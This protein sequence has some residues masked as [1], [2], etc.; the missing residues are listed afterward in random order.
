MPVLPAPAHHGNGDRIFTLVRLFPDHRAIG[1]DLRFQSR[2]AVLTV[3]SDLMDSEKFPLAN[4]MVGLEEFVRGEL[5]RPHRLGFAEADSSLPLARP[6]RRI[7]F[8]IGD[9]ATI[10]GWLEGVEWSGD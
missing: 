5:Q 7:R 10:W 3:L 6:G 1:M 4:T 8:R 2:R 9:E